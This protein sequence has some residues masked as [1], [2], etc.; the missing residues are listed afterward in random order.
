MAALHEEFDNG[1][2]GPLKF[3]QSGVG[4]DELGWNDSSRGAKPFAGGRLQVGEKPA[5]EEPGAKRAAAFLI[6]QMDGQLTGG[7][8]GGGI[9]EIGQ[10][11]MGQALCR[12]PAARGGRLFQR[13][14]FRGGAQFF[15]AACG[16]MQGGE[17]F[18]DISW[19]GGFRWHAPI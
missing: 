6:V 15:G 4:M 12:A 14:H 13:I 5:R 11:E 1:G 17:D 9:S 10:G 3:F 2:L 7:S 19:N 8:H 16:G 18:F